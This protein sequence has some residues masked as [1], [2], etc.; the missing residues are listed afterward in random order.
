MPEDA[1]IRELEQRVADLQ[2]ELDQL[3]ANAADGGDAV[4]RLLRDRR[5]LDNLPDVVAVTDRQH[6]LLYLNHSVPE[7]DARAMIGTSA[8]EYIPEAQ[9]ALYADMF[10]RAWLSAQPQ[11]FEIRT[12]G[13]YYWESRLVPVHIDGEVSVMLGTSRD[14]SSARR[15]EQALRESESRLRLA[16]DATGMGIWTWLAKSNEL[17]WDPSACAIFG[18]S[19]EQP[20]RSAR[21]FVALVH[22]DDRASVRE[23]LLHCLDSGTFDD[24]EHRIVRPTGELRYVLSKGTMIRDEQGCAAGFRGGVIDIT[25]RKGLEGQVSHGHKMEAIGQLTAGVAHNFNNLLSVIVPNVGL[26]RVSS[27]QELTACLD[28]IDHAAHR[29]VDLVQQ[30]MLFARRGSGGNRERFALGQLV[31]RTVQICRSTFGS[32]IRIDCELASDVPDVAANAGQLEQVILNICINA[33]DAFEDDERNDARILVSVQRTRDGDASVRVKDNG[34]GMDEVVRSRVFEPFFTT[35]EVGRGTGLGLASAYAIVT[36]HGGRI[37]CESRAG[38][39]TSFVIEL[40]RA[41][42]SVTA[43]ASSQPMAASTPASSETV[44]LIDAQAELRRPT[45]ALLAF[46]GYRV[47]EALTERQAIEQLA[48]SNVHIDVVLLRPSSPELPRDLV[49]DR[50]RQ[51]RPTLPILL[52]DTEVA[53]AAASATNDA[54]QPTEAIGLI[55]AIRAVLDPTA[56]QNHV[57]RGS[58]PGP[59]LRVHRS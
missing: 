51:L 19:S 30:L 15:T 23:A 1:R 31:E 41:L 58:R 52:L 48:V 40:P 9:R 35:K 24:L 8:L 7:R 28:D 33:R 22:P 13:D 50:L 25:D 47:I 39:G 38:E 43:T 26:A 2:R 49:L 11:S 20:V 12:I 37:L 44:L 10:E 57:V 4:Q 27:G 29:A 16:L 32:R 5:V 56:S 55:G 42:P 3:R 46:G 6:R 45:S 21:D 54:P 59:S 18:V 34:P 17:V 53:L 36:E 14:I